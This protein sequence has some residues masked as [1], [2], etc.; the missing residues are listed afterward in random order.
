MSSHLL[1]SGT[2]A[3]GLLLGAAATSRAQSGELLAH[4]FIR[5]DVF[6]AMTKSMRDSRDY[7]KLMGSFKNVAG[8]GYFVP[9]WLPGTLLMA[10]GSPG[11]PSP[12]IRYN[13]AGQV[14]EI[15]TDTDDIKAFSP[16][17]I[18]GFSIKTDAI[19]THQFEVRTYQNSYE[20]AGRAFFEVLNPG[21]A[22]QFFLLHQLGVKPG[23]PAL[24]STGETRADNYVKETHFYVLRPGESKLT[25]FLITPKKVVKLFGSHA[26][27]VQQFAA[28]KHLDYSVAD[29]IVTMTDYYNK[30]VTA[31]K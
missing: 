31:P 13:L 26:V 8:N 17:D 12:A 20:N 1:K 22:L 29:D 6:D 10:A 5:K 3:L 18:S 28:A 15:Q 23:N 25:E 11:V 7:T 2:L 14:L 27:E 30:L 24:T 21:G 16:R 9:Q 19:T 4:E